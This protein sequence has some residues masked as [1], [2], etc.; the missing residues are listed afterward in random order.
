MSY[1][2]G[3]SKSIL[4]APHFH[5]EDAA[6][7]Y[8]EARLWP[9]GPECPHCGTVGNAVKLGGESAP[10]GTYKCREKE[11]RRKFS[12][13]VNTIFHDSHI[14]MHIWLQAIHLLASSKKGFSAN[15]LART[16]GIALKTAWHMAHRIRLAMEDVSLIPFGTKGGAVE[17]DETFFGQNP[18]VPGGSRMA[19]RSMNAIMTLVDRESGRARSIVI[20]SVN[21][22][23]VGKVL[24]EHVSKRARL[25]TDEGHHYKPHGKRFKS[26]EA[27]NHG[28]IRFRDQSERAHANRRELLLGV[29]AWHEGHLSDRLAQAPAPLLRGVRLPLF[30]PLRARC[31]RPGARGS[32]ALRR[33]GQ[34]ADLYS[35]W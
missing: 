11:C 10:K 16:L 9:Q 32:R 31:W 14:P 7:A 22:A 3:M 30:E 27:V 12:V 5:D 6:L 34:A 13:R 23:E 21:A 35:N 26:H 15:Q 28:R 25:M 19:I 20:D 2:W 24:R 18:E 1:I 8:V 17:A 4:S 33:E 29:Q